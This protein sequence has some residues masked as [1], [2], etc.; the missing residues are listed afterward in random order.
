M[1]KEKVLTG[2]LALVKVNGKVIGKMSDVRI[3]ESFRRQIVKGLGTLLP[4]EVA[5]TDW[6]ST[7]TCGFIEVDYNK[8][9][10]PGAVRRNV[11][12]AR[13][14]VLTGGASFEDNLLFDDEGVQID[15]FKKISDAFDSNGHPLPKLKVYASIA[16]MF[17]DSDAID[18]RDGAISTRNQSFMCTEPVLIRE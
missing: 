10:I 6:S 14:Q 5:V 12:N 13:S 2:A 8:A 4:D 1:A 15:I 7:L 11:Q 16:K 17:I 9:G 18:I 3:S